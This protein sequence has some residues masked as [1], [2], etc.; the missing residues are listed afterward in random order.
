MRSVK[1]KHIP[2]IILVMVL[3]VM[4]LTNPGKE[5]FQEY[6]R[7]QLVKRKFTEQY[8]KDSLILDGTS[9]YL[10]VSQYSFHINDNGVPMQGTYVGMFNSFFELGG[11]TRKDD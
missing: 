1:K 8:I 3:G 11:F 10:F 6:A 4:A 7:K 5:H 9:N 2:F